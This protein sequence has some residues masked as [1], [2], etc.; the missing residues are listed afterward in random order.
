MSV[1]QNDA[2]QVSGVKGVAGGYA[3]AAPVGTTLPTSNSGSLNEAFVNLGYISS[4]GIVE[5]LDKTSTDVPDING[6]VVCVLD[7][8]QKETIKV[9]LISLNTI[10]L[11]EY[12]G[13]SN[14]TKATNLLTVKHNSNPMPSR[15]YV[16]ELLLKD[17]RKWRKV[18]PNGQ[19]TDLADLTL[20]S[21][22]VFGREMT[23]NCAPDS[24]GNRQYDYID[25][26][27]TT[28]TTGA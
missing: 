27:A 21:G 9:T 2:T 6:D 5:G 26:T 16:F 18:V 28:T 11:K 24:S 17:G 4:G 8:T 23:I 20:A 25:E 13:Q 14:V 12:Y 3:F 15:S 7:S 1:T 22:T 19:V 10:T